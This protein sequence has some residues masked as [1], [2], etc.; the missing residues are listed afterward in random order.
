MIQQLIPYAPFLLLLLTISSGFLFFI[1]FV[2]T[3]AI[4]V[5]LG[6][7]QAATPGKK[8]RIWLLI[9]SALLGIPVSLIGLEA[10]LDGSPDEQ[11]IILLDPSRW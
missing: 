9:A 4:Q 7:G 3:A 6:Y 1:L 8:V 5:T 2:F 11:R 10:S